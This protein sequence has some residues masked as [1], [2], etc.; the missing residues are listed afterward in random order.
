[1]SHQIAPGSAELRQFYSKRHNWRNAGEER[2]RFRTATRLAKVKPASSV[3]DLGSRNGDLREYLP[4]DVK[5]QGVDIAPEFAAPEILIHDISTGL[6]FPDGT[7]DYV[8]MI[9]VLEHAPHPFATASEVRR[10]LKPGGTWVVSV[11]NP[12]HFKELIWN[13]LGVPDHQGHIFSWTRQTFSRFA[14]MAGFH[15]ADLAGTYLYPPI[16]APWPL[17]RSVAYKLVRT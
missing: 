12:Y 11:P 1:M 3:L 17:A 7:F 2:I 15:L 8:F 5:Y 13:A 6:P 10:V 16:P 14:E 9:E 4:P